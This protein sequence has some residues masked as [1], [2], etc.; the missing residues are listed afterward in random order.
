M[1]APANVER[2]ELPEPPRH[3]PA[4]VDERRDDGLAERPMREHR[5][6]KHRGRHFRHQ[7]IGDGEDAGGARRAVEGGHFAEDGAGQH[8]VEND[9]LA[10]HVEHCAQVTGHDEIDVAIMRGLIKDP[11]ACLYLQP[12]A[13]AIQ[14]PAGFGIER[15]ETGVRRKRVRGRHRFRQ[16]LEGTVAEGCSDVK[17]LWLLAAGGAAFRRASGPCDSAAFPFRSCV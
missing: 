14:N 8:V 3:R 17:L 4:H 10:R 13:L 12:D 11:S 16:H 7:R 2:I 1:D 5:F 6:D 15:L 9:V